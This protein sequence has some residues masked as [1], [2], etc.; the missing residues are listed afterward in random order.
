MGLSSTDCIRGAAGRVEGVTLRERGGRQH[1][2]SVRTWSSAQTDAPLGSPKRVGAKL[3]AT[4]VHRATTVYGYF[5]GIPNRGYR[6]FFG[7]GV[8]AGVIPTNGGLHCVFAACRPADYKT[9]FADARSGM[10]AILAGF[11]PEIAERL[12]AV[13]PERLRR[14]PGA[15]GHVRTRVGEGWAL[16]GDAA[17]F[18]DPATAHG[19]TDALLDAR[20]LANCLVRAETSAYA[21]ERHAQSLRLFEISQKVASFDWSFDELQELHAR[22][23]AC[24]KE[25]HATVTAGLP[26]TSL[27]SSALCSGEASFSEMNC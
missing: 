2:E 26:N 12:T 15:P 22:L 5:P 11:D 27:P 19:I 7:D 8:S 24:M 9:R 20:S 25:E 17:C 13:A 23:N 21:G 14:F 6:W 4:S 3:L 10:A 1:V 18:K 16:V